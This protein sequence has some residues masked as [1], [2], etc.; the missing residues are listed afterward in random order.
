M[1]PLVCWKHPYKPA[2][3]MCFQCKKGFCKYCELEYVENRGYVCD[4]CK[5]E[6]PKPKV[7]KI[8]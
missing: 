5:L 7:A 8:L 4:E 3:K 1:R 6:V 2:N